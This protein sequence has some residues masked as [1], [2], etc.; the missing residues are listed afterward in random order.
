VLFIC[1]DPVGAKMAGLGIRNWELAR[2]LSAHA[3]VT[4]AHGG[5]ESVQNGALR[6]VPYRPHDP[7]AVLELLPDVD[8]AVAHP[9]WPTLTRAMRRS[10]ARLVFDLYDPETLETLE[11]LA[12]RPRLRRAQLTATTLDRLHDALRSGHHFMCASETQRDLWLGAMLG[13]RMIGPDGYDRDPSYRSV[14]D[15]VPFGLPDDAPGVDGGPGPRELLP[16]LTPESE[17]VLWNGGIWQWLDAPTAIRAIARVRVKRPRATLVFMGGAGDHPAARAA[18]EQARV[19]AGEL[20]L[21]GSGVI[22]NEGWVRYEERARW[23]AQAGCAIAAAHDHLE[24]RFAFRTR[25]LDCLWS[26]LPVACT[27]GDELAAQVVREDLGAVAKPGDTEG[28]AFAIERILERGRDAYRERLRAA[29]QRATWSRAAQ[30]L[31]H[32][33]RNSGSAAP[34]RPASGAALRPPATQVARR[35]AYELVGRRLLDARR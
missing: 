28:L 6:T 3:R 34:G 21:L 11:L 31:V 12:G 18:A 1:A 7:S 20:G 19:L 24:T 15:V 27:S 26:G 29:A 8:L 4:I 22:L 10:R 13:L 17:I 33:V 25:L 16:G 35:I 9:Q 30:P 5:T 32:W 23:L 2:V 14:I